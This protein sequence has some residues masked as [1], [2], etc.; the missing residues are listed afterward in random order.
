MKN[1]QVRQNRVSKEMEKKMSPL[2]FFTNFFFD[3][4]EVEGDLNFTNNS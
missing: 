2:R 4:A 1:S 3:S